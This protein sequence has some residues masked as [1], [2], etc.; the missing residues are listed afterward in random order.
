[1]SDRPLKPSEQR[2]L[3]IFD[4]DGPRPAVGN[5]PTDINRYSLIAPIDPLS[6]LSEEERNAPLPPLSEDA[7][8]PSLQPLP[9]EGIEVEQSEHNQGFQ[10]TFP[11]PSDEEL[12]AMEPQLKLRSL[13]EAQGLPPELHPTDFEAHPEWEAVDL[14]LRRHLNLVDTF[15]LSDYHEQKLSTEPPD[16][17]DM[18]A[19]VLKKQNEFI[20][21]YVTSGGLTQTA[22]RKANITLD[23]LKQW[24]MDSEFVERYNDAMEQWH[25]DLRKAAF[26]RAQQK[27][28]VLLIFML[29]ALKPDLYD[30]DIR[31]ANW[32]AKQGLL[33][34]QNLPVRATLIRDN[35]FNVMLSGATTEGHGTPL[36]GSRTTLLS[37]LPED[38]PKVPKEQL[39][40]NDEF[41]P[42]RE[43]QT[44]PW[45]ELSETLNPAIPDDGED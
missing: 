1:M 44:G 28:D 34:D 37:D 14:A 43:L 7:M 2:R 38:A 27:S 13:R 8:D 10:H 12:D 45:Q 31:K 25:E 40:K 41:A 42:D 3:P 39:R 23:T 22:L 36:S 15:E 6:H 26:I 32:M 9:Y 29:K 5:Q 20:R 18:E 11:A 24:R 35:T 21:S 19:E 17:D 30:D 4:T 33:G 16:A